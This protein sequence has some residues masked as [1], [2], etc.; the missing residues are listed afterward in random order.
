M[1]KLASL[2]AFVKV[3]E[4][5]SF[6]KAARELRLSRA[7]IS[8][9]VIDLEQELGAQLLHRTTRRT[10]PTQSGLAYYQSC[11]TILAEIEE[12]DSAVSSLQSSP[13]GILRVNAP[14]S[15]GTL[16][17]GSAIADFMA[18]YPDLEIQLVLSDQF[19]DPTQDGAD[20]TLRIAALESSSLVARKIV[21]SR[22]VIC[23][24]PAYLQA[25]GVPAHPSALRDHD[26][27]TYGYLA[28]GNQW[29]LAG[30]DGDVWAPIRTRLCANNGE[31]LRDAAIAGL[32]IALL[33][34]FIVG[35]ALQDG[36]LVSVLADYATSDAHLYALYPPTRHVSLKVRLF[37]DFLVERFGNR[38]YWDL[39]E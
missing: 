37:I 20:L 23:A 31:V 18:R 39:I 13:R 5:E 34:T 16:H 29:K 12:A 11:R 15:F 17:L 26:C 22:R 19:V 14:M 6:S 10:S 8:K 7:A 30:P 27:L 36:T 4:H 33:P 35:A 9:Y 3:V 2:R 21:P 25:H 32:G 1:D 24:A 28:S 38:P